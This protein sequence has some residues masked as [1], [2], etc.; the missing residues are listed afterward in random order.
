MSK[1]PA[2]SETLFVSGLPVDCS[3]EQA[4]KVTDATV[5][6]V[7]PGKNAAASFVVMETVD[8]AQWVVDNLNGNIPDGFSTPVTVVFATPRSERAPGKGSMKGMK[9]MQGMMNFMNMMMGSWGGGG[10][11]WGQPYYGY[12][13]HDWGGGKGKGK[14]MG[15]GGM[16]A[17]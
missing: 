12:G 1:G 3:S 13:G 9:G 14:A 15:K 7:L 8:Q 6:P 16:M 17:Y 4:K 10:K 11:G 2:P 5:L